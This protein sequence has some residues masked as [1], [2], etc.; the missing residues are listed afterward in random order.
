MRSGAIVAATA[1]RQRP[2]LA[3]QCS[4]LPCPSE[5][6]GGICAPGSSPDS[7][8]PDEQNG[9]AASSVTPYELWHEYCNCRQLYLP[10][11]L[12][13]GLVALC[14]ESVAVEK[15]GRPFDRAYRELVRVLANDDLEFVG[16]ATGRQLPLH[17]VGRTNAAG[18][19]GC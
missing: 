9:S 6:P 11:E 7:R 15:R 12:D 17:R 14:S 18:A 16:G 1:L 13:D 4:R 3:L 10:V 5:R 19:R 8:P 2:A